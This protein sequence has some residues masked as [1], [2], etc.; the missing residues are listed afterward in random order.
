MRKFINRFQSNLKTK[1][2]HTLLVIAGLLLAIIISYEILG[3]FLQVGPTDYL[4]L[5]AIIVG[6]ST[7]L[8]RLAWFWGRGLASSQQ[9]EGR[10]KVKEVATFA[11]VP[12]ETPRG[13]RLVRISD[14]EAVMEVK[15]AI[16]FWC[17]VLPTTFGVFAFLG[18]PLGAL[19]GYLGIFSSGHR[20][21]QVVFQETVNMAMT[22]GIGALVLAVFSYFLTRPT[23]R[24][25]VT[26]DIVRFG[27]YKFDR[28]YARGLQLSFSTN[29]MNFLPE[30][31]QPKLGASGLRFGYGRW[32]ED[33]KYIINGFHSA[34]IVIWVNEIIDR[35][36]APSTSKHNPMAGN[37]IELL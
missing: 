3:L 17:W 10:E 19:I 33:M 34:E 24:V 27:R 21:H 36:G 30:F 25:I 7:R 26:P 31:V 23:I 16:R 15:T 4:I 28:R 1:R 32:G 14:D 12:R 18:F 6:I 37:K 29:E 9:A 20:S 13:T 2:T 5:G 35:V 8:K 11:L 22:M